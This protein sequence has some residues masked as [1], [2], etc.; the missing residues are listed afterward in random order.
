MNCYSLNIY[1]MLANPLVLL[2]KICDLDILKLNINFHLDIHFNHSDA[3]F[4]NKFTLLYC[5][6]FCRSL[7]RDRQTDNLR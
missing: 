6:T 3:F 1:E 4:I 5:S 7:N 2:M